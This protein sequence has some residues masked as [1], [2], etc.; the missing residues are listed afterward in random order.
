MRLIP[1]VLRYHIVFNQ[2]RSIGIVNMIENSKEHPHLNHIKNLLL[3]DRARALREVRFYLSEVEDGRFQFKYKS[4]S[5]QGESY[6]PTIIHEEELA[7]GV[8]TKTDL[9]N[10]LVA[11]EGWLESSKDYIPP[12]PME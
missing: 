12:F 8:Y 4:R 11:L 10:R 1:Q 6:D 7:E 5:Q 3:R 2:N 9:I